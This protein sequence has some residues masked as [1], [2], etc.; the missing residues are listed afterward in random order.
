MS[1]DP[2]IAGIIEQLDS[3]FPAVHTMTGAQARA[4]IRSRFL[5]PV[6][7]EPVAEVRDHIVDGIPVR[8]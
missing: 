3:G 8:I 5:P 4:V 1:L 6:E 7:P 2:Q